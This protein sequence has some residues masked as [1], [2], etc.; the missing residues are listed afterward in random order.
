MNLN[1]DQLKLPRFLGLILAVGSIA[2]C[3]YRVW[4]DC[5]WV[6]SRTFD[7]GWLLKTGSYIITSGVIPTQD[8]F[9][10]TFPQRS[11]I[12]YQWLFELCSALIIKVGG[13]WLVGLVTLLFSGCLY[14]VIMPR[15]WISQGLPVFLPF[16][17]ISVLPITYLG[18]CRPFFCSF[19]LILTFISLLERYRT[20]RQVKY[21]VTLPPLIAL[22]ANLHAFW[23]IGLLI[24]A[25]Y[26]VFD[27]YRS[28]TIPRV[29]SVLFLLALLAVLANPYGFRLISHIWTFVDGSQFM[30]L[31]ETMPFYT[32]SAWPLVLLEVL[33][34]VFVLLKYRSKVPVEGLV[35]SLS[36]TIA[37]LAVIRYHCVAT[38]IAWIYM[39]MALSAAIDWRKYVQL[40]PL[41]RLQLITHF[42]AVGGALTFIW[43]L[44]FPNE[45]LVW[46]AF[47]E[48][49]TPLLDFVS[50]SLDAQDRLL[51]DPITGSRLLLRGNKKV[52]VDTRFDMYPKK[53][54]Q[55]TTD[56]IDGKSSWSGFV[57]EWHGTGILLSSYYMGL[58]EQLQKSDTW[59]LVLDCQGT[60]LWIRNCQQTDSRLAA[61]HAGDAD[62]L[63]IPSPPVFITTTIMARTAQ[64]LARAR[65]CRKNGQGAKARVL[66][67]KA[68]FLMPGSPGVE[69]ECRNCDEMVGPR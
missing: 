29:P 9:S 43:Y 2:F 24:F 58:Y 57:E 66:L 20:T 63:M 12:A 40:K 1:P 37:G 22:W 44:H 31:S 15:I 33:F 16:A 47:T 26:L 52:F 69:L 10:W 18:S 50:Q 28:R 55:E 25:V 13:L 64:Y 49:S 61:W 38:I 65:C 53:F 45:A 3:A 11:F 8:I 39:G 62:L 60:S 14:L 36:A 30:N 35:L 19:Y 51:T 17:V 5:P 7:I 32:F 27:C 41:S 4:F 21:L 42:C 48:N 56:F 6:L 54:L 23:F 34:R 46:A 59:R 68:K 67:E